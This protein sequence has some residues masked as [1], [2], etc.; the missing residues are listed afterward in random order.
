MTRGLG[1]AL[2]VALVTLALHLATG[3]TG[4]RLALA[5]PTAAS[6]TLT[7]PLAGRAPRQPPA[8]QTDT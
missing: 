3:T 4:A 6:L 1:T 2:G 7:I 5:G 8:P